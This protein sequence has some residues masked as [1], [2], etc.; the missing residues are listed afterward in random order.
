MTQPAKPK[1]AKKTQRQ[2][3]AGGVKS[4]QSSMWTRVPPRLRKG[5]VLLMIPLLVGLGLFLFIYGL[6]A[7]ASLS[8]PP[9]P[10]GN[11]PTQKTAVIVDQLSDSYPNPEFIETATR[12]LTQANYS[13][14]YMVRKDV[15]VDFFRY[16]P[17]QGYDLILLR[18]HSG[19]GVAVGDGE[20]EN[21]AAVAFSA[22][23]MVSDKYPRERKNR[24]IGAFETTAE[25]TAYFGIG[26]DFLKQELQGDF[27]GA[28]ILV[29]GCEGLRV[30]NTAQLFLDKGAGAVIG[31]NNL[32][33]PQHTDRATL[34]LLEQWLTEEKP[35]PVAMFDTRTNIGPDP[36]Y[37]ETELQGKWQL[38]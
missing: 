22:G 35:L 12:V 36:Q 2:P 28:T 38:D 37:Q 4:E 33:T 26:L 20:V 17:T 29:M 30:D 13:V 24:L 7:D 31:W 3:Q 9:P 27:D 10:A 8:P 34:Y 21:T 5:L 25:Q 15:T 32:V 11:D 18:V 16:L 19:I 6:L 23:E 1:S 14:T